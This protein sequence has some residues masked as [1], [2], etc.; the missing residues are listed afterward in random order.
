MKS[1]FF[2]RQAE[3]SSACLSLRGTDT[4]W[5]AARQPR[6]GAPR[7]GN[8]AGGRSGPHRQHRRQNPRH[9]RA[10]REIVVQI[11][12]DIAAVLNHRTFAIVGRAPSKGRRASPAR[13]SRAASCY[14]TAS[15]AAP[16]GHLGAV[17]M[18]GSGAKT[19]RSRRS[20]RIGHFRTL[21]DLASL[22]KRFAS[23][24]IRNR[25]CTSSAAA[26]ST[27]AT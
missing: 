5:S 24:W 3:Q 27:A 17:H 26:C 15:P 4:T 9:R 23:S 7:A 2:E 10:V 8:Q 1:W 19:A 22:M 13:Q 18:R 20:Q 6:Q 12:A 25:D 21:L 16:L 11:E 14:T